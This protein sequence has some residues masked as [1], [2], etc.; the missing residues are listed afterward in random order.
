MGHRGKYFWG[1]LIFFMP[2][3]FSR[4]WG[5]ETKASAGVPREMASAAEIYPVMQEFNQDPEFL[6]A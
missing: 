6:H 1:G 5:A 4:V 2:C 3:S